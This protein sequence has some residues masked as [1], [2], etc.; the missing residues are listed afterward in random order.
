MEA[1]T[2]ILQMVPGVALVDLNHQAAG[3]QGVNLAVLPEQTR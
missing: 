2:G 1:A 3:L